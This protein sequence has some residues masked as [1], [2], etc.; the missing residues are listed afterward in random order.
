[1]IG[2]FLS[3][4]A[5]CL[6]AIVVYLGIGVA[7]SQ[8]PSVEAL[9]TEAEPGS[10]GGRL[11]IG[12]RA[13]PKTLF[14][15]SAVDAPSREVIRLMTADLIHINRFSQK[16]EPALAKSWTAS[17]DG[18]R[19]TLQLRQG[20]L[21][22]DGHPLDADDV[23]F[24]FQLYLDEK[25]NSPQRD[26]LL[27]GGKPISVTKTDSH[28]VQFEIAQP[29]AAAERLF[30]SVAIL[31][32]HL[33]EKAYQ[34]GTL[35]RTWG[36]TADPAEIAGLGPF[37]LKKYIP[38]D[39]LILERNP[40]FWKAD[41][42]GNR[43]PYLDEVVFLFVGSEDAQVM[44]FQTGETD[45]ISRIGPENHSLLAKEQ[46]ARGY[47]LYDLGPGLEYNFLFF[48]LNDTSQAGL[49]GI[50]SKQAWF[51]ERAFRQAV[52]MA[53]DREGIVRLVYQGRA[54]PLWGHVSPGN[55]LWADT[56]IVRPPRSIA[57][58]RQLLARAGFRWNSEGTL[59]DS[60]GMAVDF[61]IVT[62][63][64]NAVR[65]KMATMIQADLKELGM[66]VHVVP[67]EFRSLLDRVLKSYDYEAC[68]LGLVGGDADPNPDMNVLAS[69]GSTHLWHPAQ[70]QPA[71]P[72]ETEIDRLMQQQLS[73]MDYSARKRLFDR[74]QQV[75]AVEAPLI[76]LASP[77][78]LV[79]A[80]NGLG[81]FKPAILDDYVLWNVEEFYWQHLKSHD[82]T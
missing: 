46:Q 80:K 10:N 30:D 43:L 52:S 47:R 8:R 12:Q 27:V 34:G 26:L 56:T 74:V 31:P 33:L 68:V 3:R 50:A 24:S 66:Q 17:K 49:P 13:E 35:S 6:A 23:I 19:Y 73:A 61:S 20:V 62:S 25:N 42:E 4:Q 55:K 60:A 2:K 64:S 32:R 51:R 58:A 53:I 18:R 7:Q 69:S 76:C 70:K 44:R 45:V 15:V 40:Y 65:T 11:V 5:V 82:R 79:G 41:R 22:S 72:W 78:V 71:T 36:L 14:P 54:A 63:S 21:F 48:N 29:Y 75:M 16:T 81:N 67:L 28:T 37:R 57:A 9:V 77:N 59:I 38:G 39:R 1:M